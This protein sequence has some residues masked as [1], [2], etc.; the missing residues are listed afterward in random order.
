MIN[1]R[2]NDGERKGWKKTE[3]GGGYITVFQF[4][5]LTYKKGF[6]FMHELIF[7]GQR[8]QILQFNFI[9]CCCE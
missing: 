9:F 7:R 2:G 5:Y 4:Q 1:M 3:K 8:C 6:F